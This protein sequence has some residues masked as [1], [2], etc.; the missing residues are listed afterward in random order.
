MPGEDDHRDAR[1]HLL[2][3]TSGFPTVQDGHRQVHDHDVRYLGRHSLKGILAVVGDL[4]AV[5]RRHQ[6]L[7]VHVAFVMAV[8]DEEDNGVRGLLCRERHRPSM[9]RPVGR[10]RGVDKIARVDH[11]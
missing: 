10:S 9:R 3:P 11:T 8:V 2:Q 5:S 1:V 6:L 4:D 7:R